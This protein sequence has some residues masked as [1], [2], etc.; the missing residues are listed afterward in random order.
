MAACNFSTAVNSL[1]IVRAKGSFSVALAS[2][3]ASF[4]ACIASTVTTLTSFEIW[5]LE[6]DTIILSPSAV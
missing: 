6:I 1:D 4:R 5:F 3:I 2:A